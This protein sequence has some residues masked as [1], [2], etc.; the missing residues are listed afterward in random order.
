MAIRMTAIRLS[1]GQG[2]EHIVRLWWTDP[3]DGDSGDNSRAE[4]VAWIE[5]KNG[6]AYVE[7]A[8]G[9]RAD[10]GVVTPQVGAKYLRTYA[11]GRWTNN[12]LA[13]P[14]K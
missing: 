4:I 14:R 10:V 3:A 1:G 12:L 11:D 13:L 6:K 7:D 8:R 9:N 2:H 5:G